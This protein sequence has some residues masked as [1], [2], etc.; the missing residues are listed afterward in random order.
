VP[1]TDVLT[2]VTTKKMMTDTFA[3]C[4]GNFT[5]KFDG[6]VRDA[7]PAVQNIGLDDRLRRTCIDASSTRTTAIRHRE[8]DIDFEIGQDTAEEQPGTGF[9]INDAG[10]LSE[11]SNAGIFGINAFQKRTCVDV[12]LCLSS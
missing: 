1:W 2:D 5:P 9:L 3:I 11:P 6:R 4:F 7:L 12:C 8:V 10:I